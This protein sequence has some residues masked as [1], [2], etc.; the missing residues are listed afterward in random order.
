MKNLIQNIDYQ[1]KTE[2]EINCNDTELDFFDKDDIKREDTPSKKVALM[3]LGCKVNKYESEAIE[4]LFLQSGYQS[5]PFTEF[6]DVYIINTCTVTAMSDKKS[7]QMIRR[8]KKINP[9][10]IVA[11]MGCYSQKNPGEVLAIEE[12]N[13]VLGT[14]Q[15]ALVL[16]EVQKA[17]STD[18]KIVVDD[19]MKIRDFEEM[20]ISQVSDRTRALIK[21]QD[22]CDR[23]C[24]YCIIPYTRGPVRS[25]KMDNILKEVERLAANGYKEIVL[26]GI[27]VASYGKDMGGSLADVIQNISKISGIQRIRISSVEP[28]IITRDFMEIISGIDQFC[29]HF[30]LSMQSGSDTVLKR[31]NRRYSS[32]EYKDAVEM[33]REYYKD[34]SITTDVIVG[35]P[36]ESVQ[37]FEET[38]AL[39]QEIKLYETHVFKY[40]PREGTKA[41]TMKDQVSS[42]EKNRRSDILIHLSN[43]NMLHYQ[44]N[45]IGKTLEVLFET[46]DDKYCY[47]HT[48][49]YI[50]VAVPKEGNHLINTIKCVH[51]L[52]IEDNFVVG[53]L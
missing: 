8:T 23:F 48:K 44:K 1:K 22:G 47:G 29:P 4:E 12:V 17:H 19:I 21:I 9:D 40:S 31:M 37:E 36:E 20:Q 3:T 24:S 49:N 27:H 25:R 15:R 45:V 7:R 41:A 43:E 28:L 30:H 38:K 51:A 50:K 13:I 53:K 52:S 10:S 34:A 6:A 26:T 14:N 2:T 18:K 42:E 11:V 32:A 33:I 35:F 5:V 39:L 16:S 46:S